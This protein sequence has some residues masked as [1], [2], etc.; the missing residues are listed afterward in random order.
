MEVIYSSSAVGFVF[1]GWRYFCLCI[2]S[3]EQLYY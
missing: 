3:Y 1:N 2:D